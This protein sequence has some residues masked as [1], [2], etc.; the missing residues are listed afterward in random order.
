VPERLRDTL[1]KYVDIAYALWPQRAPT[2]DALRNCKIISHRGEHD[3]LNVFENTM[4]AFDKVL[5]NGIWGTECDLRWTRDLVPV[6]SHD[7]CGQRVFGKELHI[8][9]VDFA[10]LREVL[11]LVPTLAEALDRF[12][13]KL[14][15]MIELKQEHYPDPARQ[16]EILRNQLS[17]ITPG[18]DY[19]FLATHPDLFEKVDFVP[20]SVCYPVSETN[21]TA[22][23]RISIERKLGGLTGYYLFLNNRMK[24]RHELV[25][26][27]I[28]TGFI[29]SKN[30]LFRELNRGIQW[31]FSDRAVAMM[32]V[33]DEFL[34]ALE[35]S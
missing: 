27:T 18:R 15:L 7:P 17:R 14:H 5:E 12:G 26:Q 23:S 1:R 9:Q 2:R 32:K 28:G 19:H 35:S 8:N 24:R 10:G 31:I 3:N 20:P 29:N 16:K 34:S 30:C 11:P 4:A 25:G 33:R 21:S 22:L 13:G 6:I